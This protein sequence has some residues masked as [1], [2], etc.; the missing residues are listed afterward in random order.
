MVLIGQP[1]EGS[2]LNSSDL[3]AFAFV[4]VAGQAYEIA[5]ELGSLSHAFVW[6]YDSQ[7]RHGAETESRRRD[8]H[9]KRRN[10]ATTDRLPVFVPGEGTYA[11][12]V[13]SSD[14]RDDHGD[15]ESFATQI[16]LGETVSGV[17][18]FDAGFGWNAV[19]NTDGDHDV[20]SFA[21]E[22]GQLYSVEVERG[23][24]LRS[25]IKLFDAAGRPPKLWR[26]SA[27]CGKR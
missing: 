17:I 15:D 6:I 16:T 19:G 4:G 20:F 2:I 21:A 11:F 25:D 1:T 24:L 27:S 12:T 10:L 8:S 9:G 18:G 7:D 26:N 3:H 14:Y 23:S 22:R 5:V 13:S